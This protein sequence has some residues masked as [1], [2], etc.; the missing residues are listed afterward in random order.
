MARLLKCRC[1]YL[2]INPWAKYPAEKAA[3]IP[4]DACPI[5]GVGSIAWKRA[6]GDFV[7]SHCGRWWITPIYGG[8]TRPERYTLMFRS[9][10]GEEWRVVGSGSTQRECKMDAESLRG[11]L[12]A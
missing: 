11:K 9:W 7:E 3:R 12:A 10:R 1:G 4:N 8:C 6:T 5:H 2:T